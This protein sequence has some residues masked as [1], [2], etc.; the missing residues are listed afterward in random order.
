MT[1]SDE[2]LMAYA[3]GALPAAEAAEVERALAGDTALA[4]RLAGFAGSRQAAKEAYAPAPDVPAD[5]AARVRAMAAADAARRA[6]LPAMGTVVDLQ[7]RRR[8]VPFWQLPAAAVLALAVGLATAWFAA[9]D[10]GPAGLQV[11]GLDDAA[12]TEALA[13]VAS[14]ESVALAGGGAFVAIASFRD[15]EG[16]LCREFELDQAGGATVVAVA[17]RDAAAWAVRLAVAAAVAGAE[18]YVPASSLDTVE[19]WLS[20]NGAGAALSETE[21]R[22]ALDALR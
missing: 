10:R 16:A 17:C 11:A 21:E 18:G 20:A 6:A 13:T 8:S 5:L 4:R 19:A 15:G 9:P 1:I 3:D 22:A 12:V 14:G 7:A 2:T